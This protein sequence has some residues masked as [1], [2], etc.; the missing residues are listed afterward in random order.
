MTIAKA[1][2]TVSVV[3]PLG[4]L[5]DGSPHACLAAATG[6]ANAPVSGTAAITYN[7]NAIAPSTL[8]AY[9]VSASFTSSD[10]NYTNGS[11]TGSFTISAPVPALSSLTPVLNHAN[12]GAFTLTINGAG[13][14]PGAVV[15]WNGSARSTTFVSTSQLTASITAADLATVGVADVT[16]FNPAPGGGTSIAFKVAVDTP[17]GTAGAVTATTGTT[18]LN[19]QHGQTTTMQVTFNGANANAQISAVCYNLPAGASCTLSGTTVT[20]ATAASTPAGSY[21][22]VVVFTATQQITTSALTIQRVIFAA[23]LGFLGLP[24]GLVWVARNRRRVGMRLLV[25]LTGMVLLAAL[26]GCG[27]HP[28]QPTT[29]QQVTSQSSIAIT[30]NVT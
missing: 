12:S 1:T 18:T 3:C 15:N 5:Y 2:T 14:V 13:F 17:P 23:G 11:A 4:V 25:V 7:G 8:G 22:I 30:L 10:S 9:A 16:V 26:A 20:I 6:V 24:M 27:G 28:N 19:V 21:Q 29:P